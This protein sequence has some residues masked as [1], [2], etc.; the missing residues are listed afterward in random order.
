MMRRFVIS[1]GILVLTA[2]SGA[3][4][5]SD[6]ASAATTCTPNVNGQWFGGFSSNGSASGGP[7]SDAN[8]YGTG[9]AELTIIQSDS[10]PGFEW[11]V[12]A[13]GM[14][15]AYGNG[16]VSSDMTFKISG[17]GTPGSP[18]KTVSASGDLVGGCM[19]DA[20]SMTTYDATYADGSSVSNGM[21]QLSTSS[22]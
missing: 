4:Y 18:L 2:A 11:Q 17:T 21:A 10:H 20:T 12:T 15:F 16:T 22:P 8:T 7:T 6:A 14:P 19:P 9:A 5:V 3:A 13:F 1:L